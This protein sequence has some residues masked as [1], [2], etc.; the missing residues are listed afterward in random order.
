VREVPPA[1]NCRID[2]SR[3][4]LVC[5]EVPGFKEARFHS[6]QAPFYVKVYHP[7]G[8]FPPEWHGD[9]R[10]LYRRSQCT[11]E[12]EACAL[13]PFE[14]VAPTPATPSNGPV[15]VFAQNDA[16]PQWFYFHVDAP[17]GN[18]GQAAVF[19]VTEEVVAP[20]PAFGRIE[21]VRADDLST[22]L[23]EATSPSVDATGRWAWTIDD[24]ASILDLQNNPDG[25]SQKYFLRIH[26]RPGS[27]NGAV[28]YYASWQTPLTWL[29]GP[30][31]G[32]DPAQVICK[33]TTDAL[34]DDEVYMQVVSDGTRYPL[35][36]RDGAAPDGAA[37]DTSMDEDDQVEWTD[38][39]LPRLGNNAH[40]RPFSEEFAIKFVQSS[41]LQL[42]EDDDGATLG[43]DKSSITIN[44]LGAVTG[45]QR[46]PN[47]NWF[48][49]DYRL[50]GGSM[51]HARPE[52]PCS[53]DADCEEPLICNRFCRQAD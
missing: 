44:P 30:T 48:G 37:L 12:A 17:D 49:R 41:T 16:G 29:Y 50:R 20:E 39:V 35:G 13:S 21:I 27:T 28:E 6:P 47:A 5:H 19:T 11:S 14:G 15:R 36:A 9:Y 43:D 42:L 34:T 1:E 3:E 8:T 52:K 2:L 23:L 45:K 18:V 7:S 31:L 38:R 32:G 25:H 51:S 4:R 53:S 33:D 22:V 40:G 24:S 10:F 26:R 46:V